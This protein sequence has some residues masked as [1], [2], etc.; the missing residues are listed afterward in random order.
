MIWV[1]CFLCGNFHGGN[2]L[3]TCVNLYILSYKLAANEII[4]GRYSDLFG[5]TFLGEIVLG[6]IILDENL[7][8]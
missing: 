2:E 5:G 4:L 1:K 6:G 8:C 7:L 3:F